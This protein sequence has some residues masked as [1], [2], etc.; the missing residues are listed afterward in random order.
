MQLKRTAEVD[1]VDAGS[2]LVVGCGAGV[3]TS[4]ENSEQHYCMAVYLI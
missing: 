3:L 2:L 4:T 1:L